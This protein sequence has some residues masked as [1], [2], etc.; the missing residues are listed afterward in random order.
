LN[1]SAHCPIKSIC[2]IGLRAS[3][4]AQFL[5]N[6]PANA[7]DAR[8]VG[9]IAGSGKFPGGGNG[10]SLQYCCLVNSMNRGTWQATI[11]GIS[12]SQI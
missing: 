8:D 2:S 10:S 3:Q 11:P 7:E 1:F 6:P 5:Q 9:S 12:K 4:L